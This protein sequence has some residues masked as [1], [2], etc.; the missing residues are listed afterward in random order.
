MAKETLE[1]DCVLP[2]HEDSE[3]TM[4]VHIENGYAAVANGGAVMRV[5]TDNGKVYLTRDELRQLESCFNRFDRA[6]GIMKNNQP[7]EN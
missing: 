6:M 7:E 2:H 1:F 5:E 4:K 3:A